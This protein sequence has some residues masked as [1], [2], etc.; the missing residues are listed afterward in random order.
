MA[1]LVECFD[2]KFAPSR[3]VCIHIVEGTAIS[4]YRLAYEDGDQDDLL[5]EACIERLPDGPDVDELKCICIHC[6][7]KLTANMTDKGEPV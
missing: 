2:H 1:H 7:A 4:Y 5:C 3:I 6:A